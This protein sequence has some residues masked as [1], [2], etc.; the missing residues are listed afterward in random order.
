MSFPNI[1]NITPLISV[2]TEQSIPL[3]LSSIA[4]E[5]LSLAHITNAEAEK[6]QF[7][8]G[9]L[10]TNGITFTPAEVSLSDLLTL[11]ASVQRTLRDVIKKEMLLEFKFENVLDLIGTLPEA[12]TPTTG[13][14]FSNTQAITN[15]DLVPGTN[16]Y[17]SNI[18]VSGLQGTI[19]DVTV[20]IH[21][22]VDPGSGPPG[23][24]H[25]DLLVVAPDGVTSVLIVGNPGN[26]AAAT[27]P[28][29]FTISDN[30]ATQIPSN[31]PIPNGTFLPTVTD[32]S[33]TFPAP[34]PGPAPY[35]AS[36]SNFN[37]LNPNGTWSLYAIDQ[38]G[39]HGMAINGGWSLTISTTCP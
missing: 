25:L 20:T 31:G 23:P 21:N 34:A 19:T 6:L 7:V 4:L 3:L 16:P 15:I 1:P 27:T 30:A 2:T 28:V 14:T 5:E 11:D 22:F 36:L 39:G 18:V 29:T 32:N 8:L 35:P 26:G 10:P 38:F 9:T 33:N 13:A 24:G 12:C 17:P 37:G